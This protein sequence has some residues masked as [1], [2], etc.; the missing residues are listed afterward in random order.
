MYYYGTI[1]LNIAKDLFSYKIPSANNLQLDKGNDG[2]KISIKQFSGD[3]IV[4]TYADENRKTKAKIWHYLLRNKTRV[5]QR[6]LLG[7]RGPLVRE[8]ILEFYSTFR[9]REG[10]LDLDAND[11]FQE[12]LRRLCHRLIAF[13]TAGR[14]QTP[15]KVTTTDL[16]YPRSMDEGTTHVGATAGAAHVDP[17][18]AQEG[19]QAN[20]ALVQTP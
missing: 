10:V 14:G 11:T 3:I 12:P 7:I 16:F 2:D 8:V 15:E 6:A 20:T 5:A 19:V 17:E 9:I 1:C 13:S 4:D 18:A